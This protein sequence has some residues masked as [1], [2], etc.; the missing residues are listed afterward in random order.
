MKTQVWAHRGASHDAP[1]NT[2]AAFK[3]AIEVGADGIELDVQ[4]TKDG[5]VVVIHDETI[6][7]TSNG[8]GYIKNMTLKELKQYDFSYGFKRYRGEK[9]PTLKEVMN[10]V[11]EQG[12]TANIELKNSRIRYKGM[13]EKIVSLI[14]QMG[15]QNQIIYS[16]FNYESLRIIK[17]LD[18]EAKTGLIYSKGNL[19]NFNDE[20]LIGLYALHPC[21]KLLK[22]G[23]TVKIAKA[24]GLALN[25]WTIN[26]EKEM[27]ALMKMGVNAIITDKPEL[28]RRVIESAK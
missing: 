15:L 22:R 2:M 14:E 26:K 17:K 24:K 19:E 9:I 16:S 1:E 21:G 3:K 20:K 25:V 28:C 7:R 27:K 11:L 6:K 23:E 10:L 5:E 4:M 13:E 12:I 8:K 18:A